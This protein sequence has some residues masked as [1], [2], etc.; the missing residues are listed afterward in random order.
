MIREFVE[1][2]VRRQIVRR[3]LLISSMAF[4]AILA[5]WNSPSM[6]GVAHPLRM[7]IDNIHGAL[8]NLAMVLSGGSVEGFTLSS[9][10][11]Y[12]IT[13]AGGHEAVYLPAGYLG[14]ALLGSVMFFLVNRAPHLLRGL[15]MLTGAFTVGF[16]VLFIRP[17]AAGDLISMIICIG[18]GIA[19]MVLGWKGRGDINQ[20]R[21]WRSITQIIMT[22]V[23]LMTALHIVLD[24][25]YVLVAPARIED[26]TIVNTVAEFA[27]EVMPGIS[28]PV[29]AYSWSAISILLVGIAFYFSIPR[30]LKDIP[31]NDDIL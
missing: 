24:L 12:T 15:A 28:V 14:S 3:S 29:I 26:G 25:P 31:K 6:A 4:I 11:N 5:L 30:R 1:R 7:F 19:L 22:I 23:A 13:F 8:I 2:K 27:T 17:D 9:L 18:F 16:L 10:G 20:L 21:S